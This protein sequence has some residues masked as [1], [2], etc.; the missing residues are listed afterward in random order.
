MEKGDK[1]SSLTTDDTTIQNEKDQQIES[2]TLQN[3]I[4]NL[5]NVTIQGFKDKADFQ[6]K[7]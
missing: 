5:G 1:M 7:E 2:L 3:K 6:K 4:L